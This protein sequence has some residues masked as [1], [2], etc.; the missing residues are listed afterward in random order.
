MSQHDK[1]LVSSDNVLLLFVRTSTL[2]PPRLSP[3][4]RGINHR[5]GGACV[6]FCLRGTTASPKT[7]KITCKI[8][9]AV[10]FLM[11][12]LQY[13]YVHTCKRMKR[14]KLILLF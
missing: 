14:N 6:R 11:T 3:Q 7:Q 13:G 4:R 2:L 1:H 5:G 9:K 12:F 8:L 10:L